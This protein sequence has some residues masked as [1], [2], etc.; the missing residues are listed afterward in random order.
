MHI[1]VLSLVSGF[2]SLHGEV[3]E[4]INIRKRGINI[5]CLCMH[6]DAS[7]DYQSIIT[8]WP[9]SSFRFGIYNA[10]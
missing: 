8:V 4:I 3:F 9:L 2:I 6:I 10:I 5:K 7:F 1:Y